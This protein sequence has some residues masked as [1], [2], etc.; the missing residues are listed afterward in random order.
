MNYY[1]ASQRIKDGIWHYTAM[2][3]HRI[4][5]VGYCADGC[6]GHA[7]KEEAEDHY[8]QWR[9]DTAHYDGR[10]SNQQR[11]CEVCQAWTDG[12]ASIEPGFA[13][14][15]ILCDDHRNRDE[16]AKLLPSPE[17]IAASW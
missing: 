4:W 12:Y 2:N 8:Q 16:L 5:P 1:Q 10:M 11:R 3:D 14:L 13:T 15:Y 6:L 7:T 9:L 17:M